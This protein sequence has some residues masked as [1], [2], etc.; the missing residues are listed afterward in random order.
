MT[1]PR[2]AA[3]LNAQIGNEFAAHL[4]YIAVA[5]HFDALTMPRMAVAND[6]T[7]HAADTSPSTGG[8]QEVDHCWRSVWDPF[9]RPI[10]TCRRS[11]GNP[12]RKFLWSST[13]HAGRSAY[14]RIH[15]RHCAG[16]R[17]SIS[18][19]CI[20]KCSCLSRRLVGHVVVIRRTRRLAARTTCYRRLSRRHSDSLGG[21]TACDSE[22]PSQ[23]ALL[24]NRCPGRPGGCGP[25]AK[26]VQMAQRGRDGCSKSMKYPE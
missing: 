2:F 26:S 1:T 22:T 19:W 4:Q 15:R 21:D 6:E 24:L 12:S 25:H 16:R 7:G 20:R 23:D 3:A 18:Y 9:G 14:R 17:G 8:L 13:W 10:W 5:V 11:D